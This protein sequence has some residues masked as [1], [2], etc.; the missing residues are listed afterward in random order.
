MK[1]DPIPRWSH[2]FKRFNRL[3]VPLGA[4]V[5]I[6]FQSYSG[7]KLFLDKT[8]REE[9][10][11]KADPVLTKPKRMSVDLKTSERQHHSTQ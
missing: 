7:L 5:F 1:K 2:R 8:K 6:A 3:I 4:V 10:T 11:K 9:D